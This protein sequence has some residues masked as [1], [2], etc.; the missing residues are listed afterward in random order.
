[1]E[2]T[3]KAIEPVKLYMCHY[4]NDNEKSSSDK[5][6][7][8]FVQDFLKGKTS[9]PL[10]SAKEAKGHER[11]NS[12]MFLALADNVR[13]QGSRH[14]FSI[15]RTSTAQELLEAL[16]RGDGIRVILAV[17]YYTGGQEYYWHASCSWWIIPLTETGWI[18]DGKV[19]VPAKG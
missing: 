2:A 15:S 16:Q 19:F 12:S 5:V 11:H 9:S 13:Y 1:M 6:S 8:A 14:Q 10:L 3:T 17:A 18:I 7:L 4:D